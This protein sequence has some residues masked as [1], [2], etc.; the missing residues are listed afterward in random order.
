[1]H[2]GKRP[3][4]I[5]LDG[6]EEAPSVSFRLPSLQASRQVSYFLL[7]KRHVSHYSSWRDLM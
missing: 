3:A 2:F 5:V 1:M 7:T 4:A 6:E